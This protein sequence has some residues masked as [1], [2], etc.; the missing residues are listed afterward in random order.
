MQSEQWRALTR[1]DQDDYRIDAHAAGVQRPAVYSHTSAARLHGFAVWNAGPAIHVV[2]G[3][4]S[5]SSQAPDAIVHRAPLST[6][7][8]VVVPTRDGRR[9]LATSP[10][11]TVL[12]CARILAFE[13]AIIIGDSALNSGITPVELRSAL[14]SAEFARG[15][16][17][18]AAVL[19]RLD[20]R[21]ESA[22]ETRTRLL[23]ERLGVEQPEIQFCIQTPLG[24]F[25]AD[26]AWPRLKLILEFDGWAKYFDYR[27]TQEAL[28]LERRREAALME[29][30]WRFIRL[31]WADLD[32]PEQVAAR[33]AAAFRA[34]A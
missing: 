34:A 17:R 19:D 18:T 11:R 27:P 31:V 12:D 10:A 2:S 33:L 28:F 13:P 23:L 16:A 30:G 29:L 20:R 25:R 21:A 6:D 32:R 3:T 24:S 7:K 5:G 8:P 1:G 26:Y 14:E 15:R 9:V 22:G 4:N